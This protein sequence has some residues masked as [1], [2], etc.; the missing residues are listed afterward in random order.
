MHTDN[1]SECN[2]L[3]QVYI[4]ELTLAIGLGSPLADAVWFYRTEC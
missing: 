3:L 4:L 1:N 2:K